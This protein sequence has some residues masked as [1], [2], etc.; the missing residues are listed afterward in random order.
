[1]PK[2]ES[3]K[4]RLYQIKVTLRGIEP[5]IWRRFQVP[6]D[7]LLDEL[8]LVLQ[9]VMGWDNYHMYQFIIKR[10]YYGQPFEELEMEDATQTKLGQVVGRA[11]AKFGYEYDFGDSWEHE[12]HVEKT[13]TV[14]PGK[15]Y[16]VCTD[17]QRA[18][19][20]E[21]CGGVWGYA[22]LLEVLQDPEDEEH[23]EMLEWVG[24]AF[25]TEAFDLEAV[26]EHLQGSR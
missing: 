24:G 6:R 8:H 16:P 17:G 19:P 23:E 20:P 1:M 4:S 22:R 12:L 15:S 7:I 18:C 10:Q 5:P 25:D 13:M 2:R 9:R 26:N 14:D 21:D 3:G 11:G